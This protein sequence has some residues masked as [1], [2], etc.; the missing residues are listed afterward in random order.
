MSGDAD[1]KLEVSERDSQQ[2]RTKLAYHNESVPQESIQIEEVGN[3]RV[4]EV[5]NNPTEYDSTI[6]DKFQSGQPAMND[7]LLEQNDEN[8]L[9]VRRSLRKRSHLCSKIISE[10]PQVTR[11]LVW[12]N[13]VSL[14][15]N[16]CS[17][18]SLTVC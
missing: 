13:R 10:P 5:N 3:N 14:I 17:K 16:L 4:V 8:V 12:K 15:H 6:S 18:I 11:G 9:S 2:Q 7:N 1:G